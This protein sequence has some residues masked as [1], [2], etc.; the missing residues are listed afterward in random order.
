[1]KTQSSSPDQEP[2]PK[3]WCREEQEPPRSGEAG[4][5]G[6]PGA[7]ASYPRQ[8]R[9]HGGTSALDLYLRDIAQ[10]KLLSSEEEIELAAR[11]KKGDSMGPRTVY[12]GQFAPRG[13][14]GPRLRAPRSAAARP[15]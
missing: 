2:Q 7:E 8:N 10:I 1:M 9:H 15:H 5:A 4:E 6:A 11:I 3:D 14:V 12:Q 13:E